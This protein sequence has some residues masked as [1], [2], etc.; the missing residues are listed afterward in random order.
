MHVLQVSAEVSALSEGLLAIGAR[1]RSLASVLAEMVPQIAALFERAIAARV[2]ALEVK[3]DAMGF[4]ILHLD[5][6]V[7]LSWDALEGLRLLG[8][9]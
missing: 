3:F 1:E 7:P 9:L 2:L 8:G 4:L 5:G 6:L